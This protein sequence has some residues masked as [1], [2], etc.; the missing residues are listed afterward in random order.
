MNEVCD[1]TMLGELSGIGNPTL[2]ERIDKSIVGKLINAKVNFGLGVPI[3][4]FVLNLLM[5]LQRNSINR[6]LENFREGDVT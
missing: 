1:K 2:R 6:S 5:T 4:I 3:K